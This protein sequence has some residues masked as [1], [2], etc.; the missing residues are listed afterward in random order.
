MRYYY[1]H[2]SVLCAHAHATRT[3]RYEELP[4]QC[5]ATGGIFLFWVSVGL[6]SLYFSVYVRVVRS[7]VAPVHFGLNCRTADFVDF[8]KL[9]S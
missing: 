8:N 7:A 3:E 2:T 1:I 5:V 4:I 6:R 9:N